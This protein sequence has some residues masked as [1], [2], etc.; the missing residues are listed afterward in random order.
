MFGLL[1]VEVVVEVVEVPEVAELIRC[2]LVHTLE[3]VEHERYFLEIRDMQKVS[4]L[5]ATLYVGGYGWYVL[6]A[7]GA[8][9]DAL[10]D[11]LF[12][13]DCRG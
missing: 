9:G 13:G 4:V 3:A 6:F 8:G 2:V 7:G 1:E 12:A 11:P 10:C 5:G